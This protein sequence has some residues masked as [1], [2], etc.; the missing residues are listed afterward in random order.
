MKKSLLLIFT[1]FWVLLLCFSTFAVP[2]N[3]QQDASSDV[4]SANA[5]SSDTVS[6]FHKRPH[7]EQPTEDSIE[8]KKYAEK[9]AE[10]LPCDDDI[11]NE[12]LNSVID[13]CAPDDFD[14]YFHAGSVIIST[15]GDVMP[16]GITYKYLPCVRCQSNG[17]VQRVCEEGFEHDW[18]KLSCLCALCGAEFKLTEYCGRCP[19][20]DVKLICFGEA[21][22]GKEN[23]CRTFSLCSDCGRFSELID[24]HHKCGE[25]CKY[26]R[27][28]RSELQTA[29]AEEI[30]KEQK[31]GILYLFYSI[32][33][34]AE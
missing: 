6:E 2:Y 20:T 24:Y 19:T 21:V 10:L 31:K 25:D 18:D 27:Y 23:M 17:C 7:Y 28:E 1:V 14:S 4:E 3:T 22:P 12:I 33:L 32:G 13:F 26:E 9:C 30:M 5:A 16:D 34:S 15:Y 11:K 29:I 8:L